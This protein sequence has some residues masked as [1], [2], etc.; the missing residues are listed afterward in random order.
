M[1]SLASRE[2]ARGLTIPQLHAVGLD[3][4][5]FLDHAPDPPEGRRRGNKGIGFTAIRESL[6]AGLPILF[7]EDDIDLAPDFTRY[8]NAAMRHPG[9]VVYFYLN[10]RPDR[11]R[12]HYGEDAYQAI[13][14]KRPM[15]R[16]LIRTRHYWGLFGTQCVLIPHAVA[17]GLLTTPEHHPDASFDGAFLRHLAESSTPVMVA[18]PNPVQHRHDRTGRHHDSS[19]KRSWS[20]HVPRLGGRRAKLHARDVGRVFPA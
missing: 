9:V 8:L 1:V 20:F 3:V 5:V 18:V 17:A 16:S 6:D 4:R 7:T 12:K 13:S 14:G 11:M 2:A 15:H 19:V 10:E